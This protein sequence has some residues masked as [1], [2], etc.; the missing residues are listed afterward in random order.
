LILFPLFP[1]LLLA[2]NPLP[3]MA[4]TTPAV[5]ANNAASMR[6][7]LHTPKGNADI[8]AALSQKF[9]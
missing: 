1:A 8:A 7:H 4:Q 3:A 5:P 9:E 2:S 6:M